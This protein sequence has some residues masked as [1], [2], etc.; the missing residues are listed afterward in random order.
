MALTKADVAGGGTGAASLTDHGVL[1]GSGTGAVSVTAAGTSG[2]VL[3]SG[4]SGADPDWAA[5]AGG[6]TY[7]QSW[8]LTTVEALA[9]STLEYLTGFTKDSYRA[10]GEI[11]TDMAES[12]GVWTFPATGLWRVY[13]KMTS[14]TY[15]TLSRFMQVGIYVT[16]N[17]SDYDEATH[18]RG[19]IYPSGASSAYASAT[20]EALVNVTS[21]ANVKVKIGA[22][23][24]DVTGFVENNGGT[25]LIFERIGVAD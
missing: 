16:D 13:C 6:V 2:Q 10:Y 9:A 8:H 7:V 5:A 24:Q 23:L 22:Y 3:T 18:G 14:L 25:H 1:L 17:N 19:V 21:T 20:V 12:G 11:G 4:G 15:P